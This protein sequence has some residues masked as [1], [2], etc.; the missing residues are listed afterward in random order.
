[1][2]FNSNYA[3]MIIIAILRFLLYI[4]ERIESTI[5]ERRRMP[6]L[7]PPDDFVRTFSKCT[8]CISIQNGHLVS[9]HSSFGLVHFW[10]WC[11][12]EA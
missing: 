12:C 6:S 7:S 11:A 1:M 10:Q 2:L 5:Y 3:I 8:S 9:C 4:A